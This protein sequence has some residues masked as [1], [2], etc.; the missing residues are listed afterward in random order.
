LN[1]DSC[2]RARPDHTNHVWSYNFMNGYIES[3]NC[4]FRNEMLNREI[5]DTVIEARVL[6][7]TWR[8]EYNQK[9]PHSSRGYR[10]PAPDAFFLLQVA[11]A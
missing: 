6:S 5:F 8:K 1:D 11:S 4:K 10:P 7:E 9:R 3:F 2:I